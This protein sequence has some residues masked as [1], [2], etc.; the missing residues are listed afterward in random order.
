MLAMKRIKS[1]NQG[2]LKRLARAGPKRLQIMLN[3]H[4]VID[5]RDLTAHTRAHTTTT[6][7]TKNPRKGIKKAGELGG[8]AGRRGGETTFPSNPVQSAMVIGSPSLRIS[9]QIFTA[10]P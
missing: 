3:V 7:H 2:C 4:T 6:Y 1:D 9:A 8:G 10:D 5:N